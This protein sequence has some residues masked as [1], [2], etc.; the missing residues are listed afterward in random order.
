MWSD[1]STGNSSVRYRVFLW[2]YNQTGASIKIGITVGNAGSSSYSIHNL[3]D[4]VQV[5]PI[6]SISQL[7]ICGAAALVGG[8]MDSVTPKNS[9]V[10]AGLLG[11]VKEWIVPN[12]SIVGGIVEFTISN[13]VAN[14]P[15]NYR[16]RTVAAN[17]TTADLTKNTTAVVSYYSANNST[18]PRG[19]WNFADIKSSVSYSAGSGWKY[20]NASNGEKDNLM[21]ASTSYKDPSVTDL[22]KGPASSNKGHYGIKYHLDVT[23]SNNTGAE[24][25]IKIYLAA[26]GT[27]YYAGAVLWSGEGVAYKVPALTSYL[28]TPGTNQKAVEVATVKIASGATITRTITMSTAGAGSTPA[29]IAFQTV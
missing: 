5:V 28:D 22:M 20:Y 13:T 15:M 19:S 4:A 16:V 29:L 26:R 17:N 11:V 3:N 14:T 25:T 12:G 6:G 21:T 10:S 2:H 24:K 7:G 1:T 9:S 27:E 18:H 23:L 8:T